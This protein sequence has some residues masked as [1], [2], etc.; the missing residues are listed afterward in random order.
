VCP[1]RGNK[2]RFIGQIDSFEFNGKDNPNRKDYGRQTVH[3]W[4]RWN[5]LCLVLL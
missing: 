4:R 5:D 2:M 1:R 3:V